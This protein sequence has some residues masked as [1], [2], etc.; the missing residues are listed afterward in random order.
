MG[1]LN[2]RHPDLHDLPSSHNRNGVHLLFYLHRHCLTRWDIESATHSLGGTLDHILIY[3]LI[4]SRVLCSSVPALFSD[5]VALRL[6]YFLP[7]NLT[8]LVTRSRVVVL[9]EYCHT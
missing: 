2:A 1:D 8:I 5:H 7:D 6:H 9:P 3:G 4:A